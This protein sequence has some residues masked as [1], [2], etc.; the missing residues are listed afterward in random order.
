MDHT[1]E[2][3][4][5]S[6]C[7][8]QRNRKASV[9]AQQY[10]CF[11]G[12]IARAGDAISPPVPLCPRP[13]LYKVARFQIATQQS[14]SDL[15]IQS[16]NALP[17]ALQKC[18]AMDGRGAIVALPAPPDRSFEILSHVDAQPGSVFAKLLQFTGGQHHTTLS[19]A[20]N[21]ASVVEQPVAPGQ[22]KEF[23]DGAAFFLVSGNHVVLSQSASVR[24][25]QI[26]AY[27]NWLL[28]E[29]NAIV[30]ANFLSLEDK[31][32][33][34]HYTALSNIK[35]VSI[36]TEVD[37]RPLPHTRGQQ[38]KRTVT[39]DAPPIQALKTLLG[40]NQT[41]NQLPSEM[42]DRGTL[43][44]RLELTWNT[45]Q[46]PEPNEF[47]D[48]VANVLSNSDLDYVIYPLSGGS[49]TSDEIKIS[50][51]VP[52][53]VTNAVPSPISMH[54][55]MQTFLATLIRQRRI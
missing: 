42:L 45:R 1:L 47:M 21:G 6:R 54:A 27:L 4:S 19:L 13:V 44:V 50:S 40:M 43:K 18:R 20:A 17:T 28:R 41:T 31:P 24:A 36:G 33:P 49:I 8:H 29:A 15:L 48:G 35:S 34:Q 39:L 3:R 22:G 5:I 16:L 38:K 14:C 7:R 11:A 46:P 52:V 12:S 55:A 9:A 32:N 23:V 10:F 26:Q 37:T 2:I 51:F 53:D 25:G 30:P